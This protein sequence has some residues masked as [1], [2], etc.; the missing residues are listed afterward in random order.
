[1][2][3]RS[4]LPGECS[5]PGYIHLLLATKPPFTQGHFSKQKGFT[6]DNLGILFLEK[7]LRVLCFAG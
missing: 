3:T 6:K 1:M 5:M 2:K 7:T 4:Y